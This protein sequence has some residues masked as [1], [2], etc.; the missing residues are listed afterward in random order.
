MIERIGEMF[1]DAQT[2]IEKTIIIVEYCIMN[3]N[4]EYEKLAQELINID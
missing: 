4:T 3:H 2:E 1:M